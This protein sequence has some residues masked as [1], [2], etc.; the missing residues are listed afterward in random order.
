MNCARPGFGSHPTAE[1]D[2]LDFDGDGIAGVALIDWPL[3]GFEKFWPANLPESIVDCDDKNS[4]VHP[5]ATEISGNDVDE[6]CDGI[7]N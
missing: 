6:D 7:A 4:S 2:V 5:L 3:R 1:H